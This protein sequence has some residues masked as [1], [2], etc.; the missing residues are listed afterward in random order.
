MNYEVRQS[1]S[2]DSTM[3]VEVLQRSILDVCGRD[4]GYDKSILNNWIENKT[5]DNVTSWIHHAELLSFSCLSEKTVI[6][7]SLANIKGEILLLYVLPAFVGKGVGKLLYSSM[8]DSLKECGVTRV[9]SHST[10]TAKP[11]YLKMGFTQ[12]DK[13]RKVGRVDG[14][15]PLEKN[16]EFSFLE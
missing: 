7:F 13:A 6:G 16:I 3:V 9:V 15:F 5:V 4:Y 2:S 10:I 11:F 14:E 12:F 1:V 8:E